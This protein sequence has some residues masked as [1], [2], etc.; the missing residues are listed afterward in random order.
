MNARTI[1]AT[2]LIIFS[3]LFSS[4]AI[5]QANVTGKQTIEGWYFGYCFEP[6]FLQGWVQTVSRLEDDGAGGLHFVT[7]SKVHA[8][9]VGYYSGNSYQWN[10]MFQSVAVS[11]AVGGYADTTMGRTHLIS[12]GQEWNEHIWI[13]H[14][15]TITPEGDIIV[16]WDIFEP[17]C[18]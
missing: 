17:T 7:H 9:G 10:D 2:T 16:E 15:A 14:H 18:F 11:N 4:A 12:Q 13:D 8:N 3:L 5:A 1:F 6:I